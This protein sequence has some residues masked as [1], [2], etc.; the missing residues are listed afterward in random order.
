LTLPEA[1]HVLVRV[2]DLQGR[3]V[4]TVLDRELES[5]A[6]DITWD[7]LDDRGVLTPSGIYFYRIEQGARRVVRRQVRIAPVPG[8]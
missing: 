2:F 5:G 6:Q 1:G 7:G 8:D 3:R 4:R